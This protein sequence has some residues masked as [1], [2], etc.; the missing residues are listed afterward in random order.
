MSVEMVLVEAFFAEVSEGRMPTDGSVEREAYAEWST[1]AD[2]M[3]SWSAEEQAQ[4][5]VWQDC[6]R[7][8]EW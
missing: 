8:T 7:P 4:F 1:E 2:E 3:A 6:G 5:R